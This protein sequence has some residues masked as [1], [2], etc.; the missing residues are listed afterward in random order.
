MQKQRLQ[1]T[2]LALARRS[3]YH[4]GVSGSGWLP[5]SRTVPAMV[6]NLQPNSPVAELQ[7]TSTP[8]AVG[9]EVGASR[10][11]ACPIRS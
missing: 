9:P 4:R 5:E 1:G 2:T 7:L 6:R 10:A 3:G 8:K 11:L